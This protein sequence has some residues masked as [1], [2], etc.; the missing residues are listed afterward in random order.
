[1]G[2]VLG[3]NVKQLACLRLLNERL[4]SKTPQHIKVF[5]FLLK[6][7]N[8]YTAEEIAQET[9]VSKRF[10]ALILK[11]LSENRLIEKEGCLYRCNGIAIEEIIGCK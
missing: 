3:L 9:G 1:V 5:E 8:H 6:K 11:E 10:T 2:R 4:P 7:G